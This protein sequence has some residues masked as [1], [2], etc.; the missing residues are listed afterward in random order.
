MVVL[1]L[2]TAVSD[3]RIGGVIGI[4]EAGHACAGISTASE[5]LSK[6][7]RYPRTMTHYGYDRDR[8]TVAE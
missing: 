8:Q 3:E 6:C 7:L 1:G 2:A 5:S 4:G